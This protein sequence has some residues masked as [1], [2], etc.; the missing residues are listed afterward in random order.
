MA[1]PSSTAAPASPCP[2]ISG[3]ELSFASDADSTDYV[4]TPPTSPTR[5]QQAFRKSLDASV[6]NNAQDPDGIASVLSVVRVADGSPQHKIDLHLAS[7]ASALPGTPSKTRPGFVQ[8]LSAKRA[9]QSP[10]TIDLSFI[11]KFT[12]H[13]SPGNLLTPQASSTNSGSTP[14]AGLDRP[15]LLSRWSTDSESS[16]A[17]TS[18]CASSDCDVCCTGQDVDDG[19]EPVLESGRHALPAKAGAIDGNE[20]SVEDGEDGAEVLTLF[21]DSFFLSPTG[22]SDAIKSPMPVLSP[23]SQTSLLPSAPKPHQHG[24]S[25][26]VETPSLVPS[27]S[28]SYF[29]QRPSHHHRH[30]SSTAD[31]EAPVSSKRKCHKAHKHSKPTAEDDSENSSSSEGSS[32][33]AGRASGAQRALTRSQGLRIKDDGGRS[34]SRFAARSLSQQ[35]ALAATGGASSSSPIKTAT[36]LLEGTISPAA[37]TTDPLRV[38]LREMPG[39]LT[40]EAGLSPLHSPSASPNNPLFSRSR[41]TPDLPRSPL[42]ITSSASPSPI[43]RQRDDLFSCSFSFTPKD[44]AAKPSSTLSLP[45][46]KANLPP[47]Q[48]DANTNPY[49]AGYA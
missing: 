46:P 28:Q 17:G 23:I 19:E 27:R 25:P 12:Q 15:G 13:A 21:Q 35:L 41:L 2:S 11:S 44:S 29:T 48:E 16:E 34:R 43:P 31:S 26:F 3:S 4:A 9:R 14:K 30:T 20:S 10:G 49:F 32:A 22:A 7:G 24:F 33:A 18:S 45:S 37:T 39:A 47:V 5:V 36:A 1:G 42:R 8:S 40:P 6:T 38:K